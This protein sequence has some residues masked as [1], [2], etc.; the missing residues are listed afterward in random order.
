MSAEKESSFRCGVNVHT[1]RPLMSHKITMRS[2]FSSV[3]PAEN[4]NICF[5]PEQPIFT[6]KLKCPLSLSRTVH[7]HCY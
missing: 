4:L 3:S 2:D 5:R 7:F 6:L 1:L